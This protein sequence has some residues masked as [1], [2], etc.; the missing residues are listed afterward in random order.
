MP[1]PKKQLW[2]I[3]YSRNLK[4]LDNLSSLSLGNIN[5]FK[6]FIVIIAGP[7]SVNC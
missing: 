7:I 2:K 3:F 1:L 4:S 5:I 6:F